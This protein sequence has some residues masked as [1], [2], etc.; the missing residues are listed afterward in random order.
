[1]L[2]DTTSA[3]STSLSLSNNWRDLFSA[4]GKSSSYLNNTFCHVCQYLN[5]FFVA[6]LGNSRLVRE[7]DGIALVFTVLL[8]Y[9]FP[10]NGENGRKIV[11]PCVH[12]SHVLEQML[13]EYLN[14]LL[15][16]VLLRVQNLL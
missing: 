15:V 6:L 5:L 7:F 14:R 2:T 16:M 3:A 8:K 4:V 13:P 12:I 10:G 11:L 9:R 1:M